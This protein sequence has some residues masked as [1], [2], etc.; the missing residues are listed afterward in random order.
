MYV[1][2]PLEISEKWSIVRNVFVDLDPVGAVSDDD[3]FVYIY[4]QENLLHLTNGD[5]HLDLGWYGGNDFSDHKTGYCIHFFRGKNWNNGQ[6]LVK[7]RSREKAD[8]VKKINELIIDTDFGKFDNLVGYLVD[9][10]DSEN[11]NDFNDVETFSVKQ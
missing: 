8:I 5:Y 1:L 2:Q 3:K 11:K 9:E 6:L 10:N 7:F 4:C